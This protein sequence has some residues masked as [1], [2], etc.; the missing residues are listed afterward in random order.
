M[1]TFEL[2]EAQVKAMLLNRLNAMYPGNDINA[3]AI[4]T[5]DGGHLVVRA[6]CDEVVKAKTPVTWQQIALS[7][8]TLGIY[9]PGLVT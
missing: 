4:G 8:C 6:W 2:D 5:S 1:I 3:I 7:W 9:K